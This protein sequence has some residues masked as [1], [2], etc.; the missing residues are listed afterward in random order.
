MWPTPPVPWRWWG[1]R[2]PDP[3]PINLGTGVETPI[4]ELAEQIAQAAGFKGD[5]L[6]DASKPDGQP[7]RSL[8]VSRAKALGFE[9]SVALPQG[10]AETVAWFRGRR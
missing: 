9:A 2:A 10:L 4:R 8:D 3:S 7:R 6:W 1:R 5:I